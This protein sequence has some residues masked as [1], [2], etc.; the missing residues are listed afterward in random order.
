MQVRGGGANVAIDVV[1]YFA[2]PSGSGG[3]YFM[4]GGNAFG[5]TAVLGTA[6][7]QPM[8]INVSGQR[9]VRYEADPLSPTI[10]G[11]A[12]VN[13]VNG[14]PGS[15]ISG[16]GADSTQ[17]YA[18]TTFYDCGTGCGNLVNG[19]FSTISG[20]A[21]NLIG[22]PTAFSTIGGGFANRT[23]FLRTT[24]GGGRALCAIFS[25]SRVAQQAVL[26]R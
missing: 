25:V 6:D 24:V 15:V 17:I 26:R 18:L 14:E 16:G 22:A 21:A 7:N 1:G 11:G 5:A 3:K 9:V 10:T 23:I 20:G 13:N 4:Q 19:V 12:A 8:D 2:A